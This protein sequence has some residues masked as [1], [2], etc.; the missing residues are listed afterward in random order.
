MAIVFSRFAGGFSPLTLDVGIR[1][2]SN[3][4]PNECPNPVL[5]HRPA[6][7]ARWQVHISCLD[8]SPGWDHPGSRMALIW[9][10]RPTYLRTSNVV[11]TIALVVQET[12][13]ASKPIS[14]AKAGDRLLERLLS[15]WRL[16]V[17]IGLLS[18]VQSRSAGPEPCR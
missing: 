9:K 14:C 1:L 8:H 5:A 12:D 2:Q 10:S 15:D 3:G 11:S 7:R 13:T 16:A 6:L 18:P 4:S 17:A